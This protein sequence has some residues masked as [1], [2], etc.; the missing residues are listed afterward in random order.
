MSAIRAAAIIVHDYGVKEYKLEGGFT[1][2]PP[3]S[4]PLGAGEWQPPK[5][6]Q[7]GRRLH[8]TPPF[9][10]S[11]LLPRPRWQSLAASTLTATTSRAATS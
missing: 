7:S 8:L 2:P 11:L 9:A 4:P 3:T 1:P 5:R 6:T 10:N